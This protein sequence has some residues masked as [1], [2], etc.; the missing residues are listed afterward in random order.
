MWVNWLNL[1]ADLVKGEARY[2]YMFKETS[3]P[4]T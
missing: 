1:S 2:I 3:G 4:C